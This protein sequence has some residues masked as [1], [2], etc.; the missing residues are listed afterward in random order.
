MPSDRPDSEAIALE[1]WLRSVHEVLGDAGGPPISEE[2][3]T[4]L[5]DVARVAAH[6]SERVA[7]P[8]TTFLAGVAYGALGAEDRPAAL[9][10]LVS[11]L[12]A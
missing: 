6:R 1:D 5:L 11:A 2:E 9:R 3:R 10:A 4:A 7:A 12:E 8:L